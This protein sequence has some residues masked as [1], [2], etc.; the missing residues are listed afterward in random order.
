MNTTTRAL[1]GCKACT[2]AETHG[3]WGPGLPAPVHCDDCHRY[4]KSHRESHCATCCRHFASIDAFDT[5]LDAGGR[6][7]DPATLRRQ[8]GRPRMLMRTT[9]LGD[10]WALVNY[11]P[12]PDFSTMPGGVDTAS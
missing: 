4:W 7:Q 3:W 11:R 1:D 9:P 12:L 6:C 5:H 8:D 2:H 10:T